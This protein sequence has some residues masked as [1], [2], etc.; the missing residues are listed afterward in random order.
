[1]ILQSARITKE[2]NHFELNLRLVARKIGFS[3]VS[4]MSFSGAGMLRLYYLYFS[5]YIRYHL[6]HFVS[7]YVVMLHIMWMFNV[8]F[9]HVSLLLYSFF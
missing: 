2:T 6:I 5:V 1:M 7:M 3:S 4:I 9:M 8:C